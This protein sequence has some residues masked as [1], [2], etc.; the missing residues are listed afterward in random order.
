MYNLGNYNEAKSYFDKALKINPNLSEI[1][2][3]KELDIFNKF[4]SNISTQTAQQQCNN[5]N[6]HYP[7]SY[8]QT[9]FFIVC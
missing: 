2:S 8:I 9:L 6:N 5:N 4:M 7:K 1:L 3:E